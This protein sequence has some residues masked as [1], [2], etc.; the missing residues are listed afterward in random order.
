MTL[1]DGFL[2]SQGKLQDFEDCRKRFLYRYIH[3]LSWPAI[4]S[5]P[6]L[7]NELYLLQGLRFHKMVQQL[8][9]GLPPERLSE[10]I[11]DEK[12]QRWWD[13]F[14]AFFERLIDKRDWK[15]SFQYPEINLSAPVGN[16][17]L[18][19]KCDLIMIKEDGT[20]T[21]YDWK[22]SRRRPKLTW[23][24]DRY[25]T[26]VYP[27]LLI[28]SGASLA[29]GRSI[30]PDRVE[31]IYWFT[32]YPDQPERIAYS[33]EKYQADK[34]L[35]GD[36]ISLISRLG[37]D[38]FPLTPN[39]KRCQYCVY[40]SLC[41]RGVSAEEI[42]EKNPEWGFDDEFDFVIDIQAIAEIEY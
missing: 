27:F 15:S 19:A 37:E 42:S 2:F 18:V 35:L 17:R 33:Q 1:Q 38:Q 4:E 29:Q 36:K 6:Y 16:Y 34:I 14:L 7:D 10:Q 3:Q 25:Q 12:L 28:E 22:T 26:R 40:R 11:N 30:D 13:N 39:E 8:L 24:M 23:L 20:C 9:T 31:M 32:E 21:I 41:N 5:E